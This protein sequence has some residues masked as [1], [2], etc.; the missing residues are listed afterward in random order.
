M[1]LVHGLFVL[2]HGVLLQSVLTVNHVRDSAVVVPLR[3]H[4]SQV[5][6]GLIS[7]KRGRLVMGV[8]REK[9]GESVA[10]LQ[11]PVVGRRK[12]IAESRLK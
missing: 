5:G 3:V 12:S 4:M 2:L 7:L 8:G 10:H 1:H 9:L 11:L 6:H